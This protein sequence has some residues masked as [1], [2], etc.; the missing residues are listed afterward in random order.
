[1]RARTRCAPP[2]YSKWERLIDDVERRT[3]DLTH[4]SGPH[5]ERAH[6]RLGAAITELNETT[7]AVQEFRRATDPQLVKELACKVLK[8]IGRGGD[9]L[10]AQ[11]VVTELLIEMARKDCDE[12]ERLR[13]LGALVP[14]FRLDGYARDLPGSSRSDLRPVAALIDAVIA[15]TRPHTRLK[16]HKASC[17]SMLDS[18]KRANTT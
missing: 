9:A 2:I 18:R 6:R 12:R 16:R 3:L 5:A 4:I 14:S 1:M 8:E 13:H 15:S 17:G 7:A 10:A 11:R